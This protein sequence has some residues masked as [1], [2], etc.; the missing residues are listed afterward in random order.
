MAQGVAERQTHDG[1]G[2]G[3]AADTSASSAST[4]PNRT[5]GHSPARRPA[6]SLVCEHMG[7]QLAQ[8]CRTTGSVPPPLSACSSA[9]VA[10]ACKQRDHTHPLARV[11]LHAINAPQG[12]VWPQRSLRSEILPRPRPVPSPRRRR[13]RCCVRAHVPRHRVPSTLGG[14]PAPWMQRRTRNVFC[15]LFFFCISSEVSWAAG[16][17]IW[18]GRGGEDLRDRAEEVGPC[19][20]D[21]EC[22]ETASPP[23]TSAVSGALI[24]CCVSSRGRQPPSLPPLGRV[25]R[26]QCIR[27]PRLRAH[28]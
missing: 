13:C 16:Q 11:S 7:A 26:A 24:F 4:L 6:S 21:D 27:V 12:K 3:R 2:R 15:V 28:A 10:T 18:A 19:L 9:A 22:G 5:L 1:S 8:K 14:L 17:P 23:G 25:M 20:R